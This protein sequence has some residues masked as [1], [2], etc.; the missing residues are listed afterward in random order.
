M[1][2]KKTYR[3]SSKVIVWPGEQGAWH[4][5]HVDAK[6][7]AQIRKAHGAVKRGFG[8]IPVTAKIGKTSWDTSIFYENRS[9]T[10]ILPLKLKIR[11]VEGLSEGD[12]VSYTLTIVETLAI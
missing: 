3:L 12:S 2:A 9:K 7:S 5:M 10:Y 11:Q 6:K 8:S 4:M 1:A